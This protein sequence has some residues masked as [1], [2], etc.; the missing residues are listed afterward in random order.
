MVY[1]VFPS[2]QPLLFLEA[3]TLVWQA[4]YVCLETSNYRLDTSKVCES[5]FCYDTFFKE[6]KLENSCFSA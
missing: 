2:I 3:R 6:K 4:Y 1:K 5:S